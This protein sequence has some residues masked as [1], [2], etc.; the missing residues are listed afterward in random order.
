MSSHTTATGGN[1]VCK[2]TE[3][4]GARLFEPAAGSESASRGQL[5][6]SMS[7]P[8]PLLWEQEDA[9]VSA[10]KPPL[11]LAAC[12]ALGLFPAI[13]NAGFI[14]TNTDTGRGN[15]GDP[16]SNHWSFLRLQ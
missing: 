7:L 15:N 16:W 13:P 9:T 1:A 3:S 8:I 4:D 2:V 10:L 6:H 14:I 12:L 11:K 5:G